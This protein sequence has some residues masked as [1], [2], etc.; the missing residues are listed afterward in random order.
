MCEIVWQYLHVFATLYAVMLYPFM[1][2]SRACNCIARSTEID[3]Y[4]SA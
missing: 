2:P 4:G 1:Y 3:S